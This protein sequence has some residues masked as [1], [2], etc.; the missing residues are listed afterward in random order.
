MENAIVAPLLSWDERANAV[1]SCGDVRVFLAPKIDQIFVEQLDQC[2][3]LP[4]NS[5][6]SGTLQARR[7]GIQIHTNE[8]KHK[9][10]FKFV[11]CTLAL[12][13]MAQMITCCVKG[14]HVQIIGFM[15]PLPLHSCTHYGDRIH[16]K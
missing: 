10:V 2:K 6:Q 1:E 7:H 5:N 14:I 15:Y 8:L 11:Q 16:H 12:Y 9:A 3:V 13:L 4:A